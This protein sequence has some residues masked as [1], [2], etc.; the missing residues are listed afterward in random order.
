MALSVFD[1]IT[2]ATFPIKIPFAL[3]YMDQLVVGPMSSALGSH[4]RLPELVKDH[5]EQSWNH[6]R[7]GCEW[8]DLDMAQ[9]ITM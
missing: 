7:I 6:S 5:L 3:H 1:R 9:H 4:L 8:R 2:N